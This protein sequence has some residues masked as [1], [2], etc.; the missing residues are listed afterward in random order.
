MN[1]N[2]KIKYIIASLFVF[3]V[4][5]NPVYAQEVCPKESITISKFEEV[6]A[7]WTD[8][9]GKFKF[10]PFPGGTAEF[11]YY[12]EFKNGKRHG[13][14]TQT[15]TAYGHT[16]VGE[17]KEGLYHGQG[18][19]TNGGYGTKRV[20]EWKEGRLI[21]GTKIFPEKDGYIR[22]DITTDNSCCK[23]K[24]IP[25]KEQ[26]AKLEVEKQKKL[27]KVKKFREKVKSANVDKN[28][29]Y[30]LLKHAQS[31]YIKHARDVYR[32]TGRSSGNEK[33]IK[34]LE[35]DIDRIKVLKPRIDKTTKD[36]LTLNYPKLDDLYWDYFK[37]ENGKYGHIIVACK[38]LADSIE[39]IN[40]FE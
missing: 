21:N 40:P 33:K 1:M 18:T 6:P 9:V 20:G 2:M 17:W 39:S 30:T 4:G 7:S 12:G 5:S 8:C 37:E 31:A 32:I 11:E 34:G 10:V 15:W 23:K 29:C 19:D 14:G 16:Y 35:V 27:A 3:F 13:Q 26:A 25:T 38:N 24:Y 36:F 22:H 28:K